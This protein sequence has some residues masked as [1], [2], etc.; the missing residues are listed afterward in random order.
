MKREGSGV[1]ILGTVVRNNLS[2]KVTFEQSPEWYLEKSI[3]G[4]RDGSGSV[5]EEHQ[6]S[7][8]AGAG[9]VRVGRRSGESGWVSEHAGI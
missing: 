5:F 8:M 7:N 1:D 2:G 9:V 6:E 4:R 3:P